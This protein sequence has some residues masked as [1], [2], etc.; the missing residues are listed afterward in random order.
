[1]FLYRALESS[2]LMLW[3]ILWALILGF[4]ISSVI[5]ALASKK[6]LESLLP[7]AHPKTLAKAMALGVASSSCSFAAVAIARTLFKKGANFTSAIAF[8]FASTNLVI[9][10]GIL[11]L[12]LLGWQF[13]LAEY[14]G[15]LIM[16]AILAMLFGLFLKNG[17]VEESRALANREVW[18]K[19]EGHAAMDMSITQEG[20]LAS[21]LFSRAGWTSV[22]HTFVMEVG[23]LWKDIGIGILISG[24]LAAWVPDSVWHRFFLAGDMSPLARVWNAMA[25]PL[26]AMLSFVCSIGNVPMAAVLWNHGIS[27]GGVIAFIFADLLILPI[28]NIYRRYYGAKL[29]WFLTLTSYVAMVSAG[30]IVEALF[31]SL[32]VLPHGHAVPMSE[33][34][35][36][37]NYTSVL[38]LLFLA[39]GTVMTLRCYRTGGGEM[40]KM[41]EMPPSEGGA[42]CCHEPEAPRCH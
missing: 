21:R 19:M 12:L 34:A 11:L 22:S 8:E 36:S 18:G 41:M 20:S 3:Q 4:T 7:D 33:M 40:M 9:E 38:N 23:A 24:A 16:V 6:D 13:A 37:L 25:G 5:Q 31:G 15:G 28:L 10:L 2:F 17:V 35:I 42:H 26:V 39:L 27:F 32:G 1:M 29:A 14:I 30:L